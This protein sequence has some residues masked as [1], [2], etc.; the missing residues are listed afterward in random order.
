MD[1]EQL[2]ANYFSGQLSEAERKQFDTFLESDTDFRNEFEF[3]KS[4]EQAVIS[5]EH[6]KLKGQLQAV[7]NNINKTKTLKTW[8]LVAA[9]IAILIVSGLYFYKTDYSNKALFANYYQTP[10]NIVHP[11]VRN[12]NQQDDLTNAFIAYQKEDYSTAQKLFSSLYD[13]KQESFLLFYEGIALMELSQTDL[14]IQTLEEHIKY[15]D[16]VSHKTN[17]Y[18]ALAY[19][20]KGEVPKAK[21]IFKVISDDT[22]TFNTKEAKALLKKL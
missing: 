3:Q 2:I 13:T 1:K 6:V 15:N 5:R 19:L 10:K 11:I 8:W 16:V 7:E 17:W 22:M 18:L 12:G 9:S 21:E 14:A 4:V 20:K